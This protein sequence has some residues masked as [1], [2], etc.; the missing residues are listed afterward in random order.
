M[1]QLAAWFRSRFALSSR[2]PS[3]RAPSPEPI[4]DEALGPPAEVEVAI[5][6]ELDL[7]GFRPEDTRAVVDA[8]LIEAAR[9]GHREVRVI[10]GKGAGVQARIVRALLERHPLVVSFG[11]APPNRGGWGA[12]IVR[13]RADE[14]QAET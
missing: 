12:T 6:D 13:L 3:P 7:H 14:T 2:S 11:Q 5:G 10:H 9:I 8:Y 4:D 1:R